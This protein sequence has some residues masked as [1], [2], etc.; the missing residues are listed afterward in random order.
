M[1]YR[2]DSLHATSLLVPPRNIYTTHSYDV[3]ADDINVQVMAL[4][5]ETAKLRQEVFCFP[6]LYCVRYFMRKV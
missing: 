5:I 4:K 6:Q 3:Q 1:E 2:K